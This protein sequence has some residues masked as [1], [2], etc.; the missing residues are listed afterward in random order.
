M[1]AANK[2]ALTLTEIIERVLMKKKQILR[3]TTLLANNVANL[4]ACLPT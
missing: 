2:A 1:F 3:N 4:I